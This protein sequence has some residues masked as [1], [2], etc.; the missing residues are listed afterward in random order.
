MP[1]RVPTARDGELTSIV[2]RDIFEA[3][4]GD[5]VDPSQV[6]RWERFRGI[7]H[8]AHNLNEPKGFPV[9]I[10]FELNST[11]QM[12]C[13]FC[14]H[15]QVKVAKREMAFE[16][17]AKVIDEGER[18]GLCS[19]KLNYINEPLLRPDLV[20]FIRYAK[21]H[22][23]L[24]VY[25][26]SNGLLL[27][28]EIARELV[29]AGLSKLMISLDAVTPQTYEL[30]RKNKHLKKIE[31]NILTLIRVRDE[32][33]ATWPMVRVNFLRTE[34]NLQEAEAF[35][36]KWE[37]VADSIGFQ[38]QVQVPGVN[39]GVLPRV[40]NEVFRCSFP[41]KLIVV[42]V[43]GNLLPCCTQNGREMP[44]GNISSMTVAEAWTSERMRE[45]RGTHRAG[46]WRSE[47]VCL[48]CQGGA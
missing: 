28:S 18:N 20:K 35:I 9:Q 46:G 30:M 27:T 44:L 6:K 16:T 19:I 5:V 43:D 12:R 37:G 29:D 24:N 10:D 39:T 11:C 40:G 32:M 7:Y 15:G 3:C 45:L 33:G 14:V 1:N 31:D 22:G 4:P 23:V 26:A 8:E 48:H 41:F 21:A 13:A 34:K 42:D 38:V 17:F 47:P 36:A 25:M 2:N